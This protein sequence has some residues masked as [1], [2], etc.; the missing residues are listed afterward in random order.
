MSPLQAIITLLEQKNA[1]IYS[2]LMMSCKL[3]RNWNMLQLILSEATHAISEWVLSIVM[4][5]SLDSR[6]TRA[7]AHHFFGELSAQ[8]H[9]FEK[10]SKLDFLIWAEKIWFG[11]RICSFYVNSFN[12]FSGCRNF[13]WKIRQILTISVKFFVWK[14]ALVARIDVNVKENWVISFLFHAISRVS[15]VPCDGHN[16]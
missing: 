4:G 7:M 14:C 2:S 13:L 16:R 11:S 5:Q 9:H 8:V 10:G 12:I 3:L 1:L 6:L 15:R